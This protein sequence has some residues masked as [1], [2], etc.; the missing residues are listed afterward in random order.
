M[1]K[2]W[3]C[4]FVGTMLLVIFGCGTAVVLETFVSG[5]YG[6]TSASAPGISLPYTLLA[7]SLAFGLVLM[8]IVYTM[9][10]VSGAHVNPAVSVACL[11]D[12]RMSVIECVEYV[13]LQVLGGI[14]GAAVLMLI[15][16]NASSLG[17][18]GYGTLS[19]LQNMAPTVK[20]T[21][22]IAFLVETILTFIF[23]LVVLATT[24]KENCFSGLVIGLTL[25]LVHIFG[26]VFTGTSVNPAR[27]IGPALLTGGDA[28]SQLWVFILAPLLG[29]ILAAV[30]YRFVLNEGVT[31]KLV[32]ASKTVI[33]EV[34]DDEDE[35]EIE[36]EPEEEVKPKA[37]K[38]R[39]KSK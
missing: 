32:S 8:A 2:K 39:K 26:I 14:A 23:V 35:E 22:Q 25:T 24:K 16:G 19:V 36:E 33:E 12:G 4:E 18:N 1:I 10:K 30:F 37:R 7:V 21:A 15:L 27:S 31:P 38:P 3:I 28:L 20:V 11:I 9:G 29:G 17:A 5:L 6:V 13:V 34:E